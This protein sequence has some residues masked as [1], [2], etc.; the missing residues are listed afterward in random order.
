[1]KI[2]KGDIVKI[3]H[4][5]DAGKTG[6]VLLAD[7]DA[8]KIV[9]KGVNVV[10]RHLKANT[11]NRRGGIVDKT[12]PI[13]VSNTALICPSCAKPT[14]IGYKTEGK[15]KVRFCKKCNAVIGATTNKKQ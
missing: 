7:P 5:N 8:S 1:M 11:Q 12:L 13:E 15:N 3:I 4:G 10:K 6:E 9:V 2:K 14:R